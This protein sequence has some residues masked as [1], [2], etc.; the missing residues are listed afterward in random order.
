MKRFAIYLSSLSLCFLLMACPYDG[1][2]SVDAEPKY[3]IDKAL[4]GDWLLNDFPENGMTSTY[5]AVQFNEKEYF[6][7][8]SAED[9]GKRE[10]AFYRGFI[11]KVNGYNVLNLQILGGDRTFMVLRYSFK[12]ENLHL[13][14]LN[15]LYAK[16]D[17][18]SSPDELR[19]IIEN[20][21]DKEDLFEVAE[22]IELTKKKE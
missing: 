22:E 9:K 18:I 21:K 13:V 19:K 12:N 14:W 15:E 20:N 1:F 2:V 8:L 17:E 11:S 10:S 7:E 5:R 4:L 3:S 16:K 6:V